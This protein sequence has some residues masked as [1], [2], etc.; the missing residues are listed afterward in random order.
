MPLFPYRVEEPVR[1]RLDDETVATL[2]HWVN[3]GL[4]DTA[5]FG[6]EPFYL[7]LFSGDYLAAARSASPGQ[8]GAVG[9]LLA[10]LAEN[11]PADCFGSPG[12]VR[13]W[14]GLVEEDPTLEAD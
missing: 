3:Y 2:E 4:G 8:L 13:A 14:R 7:E 6:L 12:K 10:E 1:S 5:E 9:W 11:A